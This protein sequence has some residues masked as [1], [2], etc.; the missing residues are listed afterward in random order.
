MQPCPHRRQL[1]ARVV[2]CDIVEQAL[3]IRASSD[4]SQCK[5]CQAM[6]EPSLAANAALRKWVRAAGAAWLR[7]RATVEEEATIIGALRSA[8]TPDA[9]IRKA[10]EAAATRRAA[11]VRARP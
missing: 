9:E 3:G 7:A 1:A 4:G 2:A 5:R 6:G 8:G 11:P 10:A